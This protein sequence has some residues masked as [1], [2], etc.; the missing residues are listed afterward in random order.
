M[1]ENE[2]I[3]KGTTNTRALAKTKVWLVYSQL[4][5][6]YLHALLLTKGF[7]RMYGYRS[8]LRIEL[9]VG[10][11]HKLTVC[12]IILLTLRGDIPS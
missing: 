8:S 2:P 6:Q 10:M 1:G 4:I 3:L 5:F 9:N 11:H 12:I 7:S